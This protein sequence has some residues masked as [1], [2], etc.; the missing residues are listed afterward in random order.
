MYSACTSK[1]DRG[2]WR[3]HGVVYVD[4]PDDA[5]WGAVRVD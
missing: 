3:W 2:V 1:R 5:L 4:R